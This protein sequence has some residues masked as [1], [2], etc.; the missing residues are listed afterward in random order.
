MLARSGVTLLLLMCGLMAQAQQML[1]PAAPQVAASGYILMD[2]S[3]G[4]VLV[5][6]NA[7]ERLP[8]ASLSKIM[9]VYIV[10]AELDEGR[11]SLDDKVRVSPNAWRK[12]GAAS[13]GS[14]NNTLAPARRA[15]SPTVAIT[16]R[17]A[18]T[19]DQSTTG[20]RGT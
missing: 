1:I 12:G 17:V 9:T 13:G 3:T 11:I 18:S 15:W 19:S 6:H 7:D 16:A 2:A 4:K 5:E 20:P 14:T 8:P 10:A